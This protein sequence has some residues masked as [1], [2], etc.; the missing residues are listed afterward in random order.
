MGVRCSAPGP[1]AHSPGSL[2]PT[3]AI[4]LASRSGAVLQP[5]PICQLWS[6]PLQKF[7]ESSCL[8]RV[9]WPEPTPGSLGRLFTGHNPDSLEALNLSSSTTCGGQAGQGSPGHRWAGRRHRIPSPP[10]TNITSD[11]LTEGQ[12]GA[13]RRG[14][15]EQGRGAARQRGWDVR[16][17]QACLG[18]GSL[19]CLK[20]SGTRVAEAR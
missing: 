6:G 18:W 15:S 7:P 10:S 3:P 16:E 2:S 4:Q 17:E 11:D 1:R 13:C 8:S 20:H 9:F 19:A 12:R 14:L 5:R